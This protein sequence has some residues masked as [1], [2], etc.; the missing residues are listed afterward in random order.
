MET[1]VDELALL[2]SIFADELPC[3][4][5][6]G[7]G[8]DWFFSPDLGQ[9]VRVSRGVELVPLDDI[10]CERERLLV[11]SPSCTFL[12]LKNELIEVGYN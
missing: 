2:S 7:S 12:I 5:L 10:T 3:Y 1:E 9:M 11:S 4:V 8:H 6:S